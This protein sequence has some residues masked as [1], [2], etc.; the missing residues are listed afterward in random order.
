MTII[1]EGPVSDGY[2]VRLRL[3]GQTITL[4]FLTQPAANDLTTAIEALEARLIDEISDTT[5]ATREDT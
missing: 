3:A 5:H 4:H 2:D 1:D